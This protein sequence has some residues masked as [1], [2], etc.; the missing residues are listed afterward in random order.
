MDSARFDGLVRRFGQTRSRRQTLRG[1]AA[2]AASGVLALSGR[3]VS[4]QACK[5]DGKPCKKNSQCCSGNCAG[6]TG[7]STGHGEGRCSGCPPPPPT[8]PDR[9]F[10]RCNDGTELNLCVADIDCL[11]TPDQDAICVPQCACRGGVSETGCQSNI[12]P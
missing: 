8:G 2:L 11:S 9:V 4:A 12:C 10:C 1:L 5:S 7:G 6:G 3:G